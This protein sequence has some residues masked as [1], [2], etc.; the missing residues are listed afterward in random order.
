MSSRLAGHRQH[1]R[2]E[3]RVPAGGVGDSLPQLGRQPRDQLVGR[4]R[5][6]RLEA[7]GDGPV[8]AMRDELRPGHADEQDRRRRGKQR[9]ALDEVEEGLL[10]P[11]DVVED[12][13]ERRL[14]LEQL[15]ERPGDLLGGGPR[16]GLAESATGR[17]RLRSGRRARR[18]AA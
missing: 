6:Q 7:E 18:P 5:G 9:H 11:L 15:P 2:E 3:E 1:L 4:L 8:G 16:I 12:D 10:A 14:L 17:R 13:D